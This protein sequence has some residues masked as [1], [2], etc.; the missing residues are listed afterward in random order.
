MIY[1]I[2]YIIWEDEQRDRK[3]QYNYSVY[4]KEEK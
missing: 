4:K 1:E 2:D 3:I